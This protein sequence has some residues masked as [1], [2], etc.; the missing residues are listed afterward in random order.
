MS[1]TI[2][3]GIKGKILEA[4]NEASKDLNAPTKMLQGLDKQMDRKG[5]SGLYFVDR[6]W[7]PSIAPPIDIYWWPGM[8][9]D[10]AMYVSKGLAYTKTLQK[11]LGTRLDMSMAYHPQTDGRSERTVQTLEDMLRACAIEFEGSWDTYLPLVEFSY[12]NSYHTSIKCALFE[13]LYRQKCR[14][15]MVWAEVGER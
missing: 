8:K 6:I 4:Q 15:P 9:K 1:I 3:S 7:V 10:I 5:N 13:A 2:R 11:A 14:S 12:N